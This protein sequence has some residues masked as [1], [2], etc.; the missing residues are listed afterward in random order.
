MGTIS[1]STGLVSGLDTAGLIEQLLALER[2]PLN[3]VQGRIGVLREQQ[4]ALMDINARLL[5]FKNSAGAFR[6]DDVFDSTNASSSNEDVLTAT[7]Q[8]GATPGR[9]QFI[10]KQL[11]STSQQLS[12]GFATRDATPLGLDA[13]SFEFG[14]GRL[15]S[16]VLLEDLNGGTGVDRGRIQITDRSGAEA[17]VDLTDVVALDEVVERINDASGISVEAEISGDRIVITDASG[18]TSGNLIVVDGEGD[19]TAT[20]LGI[21]TG[22][23]GVGSSSFQGSD[24]IYRLGSNTALSSLNDGSGVLIREG[25]PDLRITARDG[26]T[27]DI[28]LGRVD[29]DITPDTELEDLNNGAGVPIDADNETADISITAK[30]GTVYE[31]NLTGATT[32]GNVINRISTA[33]SGAIELSVASS[34]DRFVVTDTTGGSGDLVVAGVDG[35]DGVAEGLGILNEE[36]TSDASFVGDVVPSSIQQPRATTIQDV[37]DRINTA[38]AEDGTENAGRITA[39]IAGDGRSLV[40]TD[41]TGETSSNLIVAST[42]SNPYAA[43]DLGIETD[44]AGVADTSVDG[45]R[46]IGGLDTIL[47]SSLNGGDGIDLTGT[48][49]FQARSG[50]S[51]V[52]D[53]NAF[54]SAGE[55]TVSDLMQFVNDEIEAIVG[56]DSSAIRLNAAG[57]GLR[58]DDGTGGTG[59]LIFTGPGASALGIDTGSSG[60]AE[61]RATGSNLQARYVAEGTR[62]DSLNGGRGVSTGSFTIVDGLGESATVT[63]GGDEQ[64]IFDVIADINSR[65]IAVTARV[66]DN[67]DGII[68]EEDAAALDG[69]T[70]FQAISIS[71]DGGTTARDLG[72]AGTAA[73]IGGSIDGSYEQVVDLEASDTLNEVVAKINDA[74]IDVSA[75]V[76]NTGSGSTPFRM[77][78]ASAISGSDGELV[79]DTGG[80]DIGLQATTRGRDARVFFGSDTPEE[81]LL[82]TSRTNTLDRVIDGVSIDLL[83]TS[84]E[85]VEVTIARD[86]ASIEEAVEGFVTTFNDAVGR[87]DEYDFFDVETEERGVLLGDPTVARIRNALFRTVNQRALNVDGSY[88]FLT[89]VGIRVGQGGSLEFDR[90]RFSEAYAADPNGVADLFTAFASRENDDEVVVDG[91]TVADEG[92]TFTSLG[93]GPLFDNLLDDLTNSVDG[94][95]TRAD[96]AFE[97]QIELLQ[98]RAVTLDSRLEDRRAQ[99]QR[100]FASLEVLLSDLQ[101]QGQAIGSIG[102]GGGGGFQLPG[103]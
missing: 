14:K 42:A 22:A 94:V 26:A 37:I 86:E 64:S 19:T 73:E 7:T 32:V 87:L 78:L 69:A 35:D 43:R 85:P 60:I 67:G 99:L 68:I 17:T 81:G 1:S 57:N 11:V 40:I 34:G 31:V 92:R 71:D 28:D 36:G 79:I 4:T 91:V 82:V 72:I 89:Q 88:Q 62:L 65:G 25:V 51:G 44:P 96:D 39:S 18:S 15:S 101:Q 48:I 46:L 38:T 33:T 74:G 97:T 29:A 8:P 3:Q 95:T 54:G 55:R 98:Q 100:E 77:N 75:S 30:D 23:D 84:D 27:F 63:I 103:L 6:R 45:S 59:N 102:A 20:D 56:D 53:L 16:E 2:G 5:N 12:G 47:L 80:V 70:A 41:G 21:S 10:V 50:A 93:F 90:D 13:I 9:Y 52:I 58:Y 24:E 76:V 66:N 83:G 49:T 61:D